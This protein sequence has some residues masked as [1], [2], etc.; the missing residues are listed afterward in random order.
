MK[1]LASV[2]NIRGVINKFENF[3]SIY[4]VSWYI[5]M[6]VRLYKLKLMLN[7]NW[8]TKCKM[9]KTFDVT[10]TL[11]TSYVCDVV[12]KML[13]KTLGVYLLSHIKCLWLNRFWWNFSQYAEIVAACSHIYFNWNCADK[14]QAVAFNGK[15]DGL[16]RFSEDLRR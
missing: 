6:I 14:A 4:F 1:V 10:K 7:L 9:H 16:L 3:C 2:T 8:D 13:I 11:M 5:R 15:N 12:E